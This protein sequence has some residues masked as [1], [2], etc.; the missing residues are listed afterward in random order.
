MAEAREGRA[1]LRFSK[2]DARAPKVP[3]ATR[4]GAYAAGREGGREFG[5][6]RTAECV[7]FLLCQNWN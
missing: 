4:Q 7:G 6:W 5:C 3:C 2:A 1:S